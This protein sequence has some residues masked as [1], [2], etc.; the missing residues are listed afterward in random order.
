MEPAVPGPDVGDVPGPRA[1]GLRHCELAIEPVRRHGQPVT[2]LDGGAPLLHGL[3][4]DTVG[5]HQPGDAV[6]A[7]PM[8]SLHERLPGARTPVNMATLSVNHPDG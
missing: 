1:G 8:P 6:L 7:L 5:P 2:G 4:A 3:G